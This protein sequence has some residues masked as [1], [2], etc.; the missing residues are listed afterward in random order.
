MKK[1]IVMAITAIL[2]TSL[3]AQNADYQAHL[4]KGK[5]YESQKKWVNALA[6]YYDAM[7]AEPTFDAVEAYNSY[8]QLSDLIENGNPGYGEYDEFEFYDAW[9]DM[10]KEYE[11]YWSENPPRYFEVKIKRDSLNRENRTATYST[12]VESNLLNKYVEFE[13]LFKKGAQKAYKDDWAKCLNEWPR[14]SVW[15]AE[16]SGLLENNTPLVQSSEWTKPYSRSNF[17][18]LG[19]DD[20]ACAAT[21]SLGGVTDVWLYDV[22]YSILT[23]EGTVIFDS[24]RQILK[25]NHNFANPKIGEGATTAVQFTVPQD[26]MKLLD[27]GNYKTAFK[28]IHLEYG[29]IEIEPF[30]YEYWENGKRIKIEEEQRERFWLKKLPEVEVKLENIRTEKDT[31]NKYSEDFLYLLREQGY[32]PNYGNV[33]LIIKQF[34]ELKAYLNTILASKQIENEL[35]KIYIATKRGYSYNYTIEN[36]KNLFE[37][38]RLL[39]S[40]DE[41]FAPYWLSDILNIY[42]NLQPCYED[43]YEDKT[44]REKVVNENGWYVLI[45]E[46][47][48]KKPGY[49]PESEYY[50]YLVRKNNLVTE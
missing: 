11:R 40:D 1:I 47:E 48:I 12:W 10:M 44:K 15:N 24:K 38:N 18:T 50:Y 3:F 28:D 19:K 6:E 46:K 34:S 7:V 41:K 2:T 36:I 42:E 21:T 14:K 33:L 16:K 39:Q 17:N 13:K 45:E 37:H 5:E 27:S 25:E 4:A 30:C 35:Y 31:I 43:I 29:K 22:K 26:T 9:I 49:S 23:D 20:K 8:K 32:K